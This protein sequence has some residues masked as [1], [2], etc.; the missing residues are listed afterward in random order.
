[1]IFLTDN[2]GYREAI[3]TCSDEAAYTAM[4]D[5]EN[6]AIKHMGWG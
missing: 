2:A 5:C 6:T 3:K 1:M 4:F